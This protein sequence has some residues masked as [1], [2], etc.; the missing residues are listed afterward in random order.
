MPSSI[1]NSMLE[2][3]SHWFKAIC[4]SIGNAGLLF[5]NDDDI[6]LVLSTTSSC[7][8]NSVVTI[9]KASLG[10][11]YGVDDDNDDDDDDNDAINI[12][13]KCVGMFVNVVDVN[14]R[15]DKMFYK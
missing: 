1:S 5:V 2:T 4:W 13:G 11:G 10:Q 3:F 6:S 15:I 8:S 14:P 7:L 9:N 12:V